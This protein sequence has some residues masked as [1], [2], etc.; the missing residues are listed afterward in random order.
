MNVLPSRAFP[1][2]LGDITVYATSWSVTGSRKTT[3]QTGATGCCMVTNQGVRARTLILQ[4]YLPFTE[5][6][7]AFVAA[8]D[9]AVETGTR[10]GF[11][12]RNVA[13]AGAILTSYTVE[14]TATAGALPCTL[15]FLVPNA[16][17]VESEA[18]A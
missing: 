2:T 4:G 9:D 13:Y 5:T 1:V 12:L 17:T 18:D 14:E 15:T 8:L 16:L 11:T 3:E 10:F 6:P 7:S